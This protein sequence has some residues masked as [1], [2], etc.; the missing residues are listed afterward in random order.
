MNYWLDLFTGRTWDEFREAGATVSGFRTTQRK[1]A[2]KLKPGDIFVCYLTG[3][4][5]W[6]GALEIT[7]ESKDTTDI[8]KEDV[9]PVRFDVKPLVMLDAE[10]GVPMDELEGKVSFFKGPEHRGKFKG[11]VRRSPNHFKQPADAETILRLLQEAERNPIRRPVDERKLSRRPMY[12]AE[13]KK[14]K[15]RI[16]TLVSIPEPE[17]DH[18]APKLDK[19]VS[20]ESEERS[21]T[22][23]QHALLGIGADMGLKVWVAKNDRG[24][25]WQGQ[26]LGSMP[27]MVSELPSQFNEAITKTIALI[28]VLWLGDNSIVAAFEVEC[29]TTIFS[30]LLRMSDLLALHPNANIKLYIVAPDA[31]QDKVESEILRPT[32]KIRD[33]PLH[34]MCGFLPFS[35]LMEKVEGIRKLG[36][37]TSL[38]PDFL[39]QTAVYFTD[40]DEYV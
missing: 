18:E 38:K 39:E 20:L 7:G 36:L 5:R 14:G 34:E 6:V 27:R 24:R 4:M 13:Q 19:A 26:T 28:D 25:V 23:I 21:H 30:G 8:W 16:T 3:V 31:R 32:F 37:A 10:F 29:T 17:D 22:E 1:Q 9:F 33:T 12:K 40:S 35:T 15:T 2:K 11:F